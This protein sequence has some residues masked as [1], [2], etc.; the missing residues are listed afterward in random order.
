MLDTILTAGHQDFVREER[1]LLTEVSEALERSD[2]APDERGALAE[3]IRQL[4]ELFLLVVVGE[5]NAGKTAFLNAM[6]GRP[7]LKEG[8]TSETENRDKLGFPT[9]LGT[10]LRQDP[11]AVMAPVRNS[12]WLAG[13]VDMAVVEELRREAGWMRVDG[14]RATGRTGRIGEGCEV[15]ADHLADD[16]R[17]GRAERD[18]RRDDG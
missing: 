5:F 15:E 6:L 4:D 8:V 18:A 12:A 13:I 16:R 2:V 3:S 11:D 9:P 7:V 14:D 1:S 17:S 10:W